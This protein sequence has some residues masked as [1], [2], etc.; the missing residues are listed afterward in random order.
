MREC[1]SGGVYGCECD[2][3]ETTHYG[4]N[5]LGLGVGGVARLGE[6]V[7]DEEGEDEE[8]VA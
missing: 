2:A 7:G 5:E 3:E 6:D 1:Q 8:I 4:P